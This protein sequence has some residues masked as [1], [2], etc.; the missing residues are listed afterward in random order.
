MSDTHD[1]IVAALDERKHAEGRASGR[2]TKVSMSYL[3]Y[4]WAG[5]ERSPTP[6]H[7]GV[8]LPLNA[9]VFSSC[10]V[11][12]S[13]VSSLMLCAPVFVA[14]APSTPLEHLV[15]SIRDSSKMSPRAY[16][17][18]LRLKASRVD[19][20]NS[21]SSFVCEMLRL[22]LA[23]E[24]TDVEKMEIAV[25]GN[26]GVAASATSLLFSMAAGDDAIVLDDTSHVWV[27]HGRVRVEVQRDVYTPP[28][29][30]RSA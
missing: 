21:S 13:R 20:C 7:S 23:T 22:F 1:A 19:I 28:P 10:V 15:L 9:S 14:R 4:Q 5:L 6:W 29:W 25:F 11:D 27:V 12:A 18:L 17:H 3:A 8:R 2:R 24:T 26:V 16:D 30:V